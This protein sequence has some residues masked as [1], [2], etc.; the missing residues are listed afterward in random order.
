M[1]TISVQ[2]TRA[3]II[4]F[5]GLLMCGSVMGTK[6]REPRRLPEPTAKLEQPLNHLDDRDSLQWD[7]N[8]ATY[9]FSFPDQDDDSLFNVRFQAPDSC[10]LLGVWIML[11][12]EDGNFSAPN[13]AVVVWETGL[14]SFPGEMLTIDTIDWNDIAAFYPDWQYIDLSHHNHTFNAEQWFHIGITGIDYEPGDA[15]AFI[16][17]NGFPS[18]PCSSF[19]WA[20]SWWTIE[21]IYPNGYNLFFRAIVSTHTGPCFE[22]TELTLGRLNDTPCLYWSAVPDADSYTIWKS[23]NLTDDFENVGTTNETQ[24]ID[25]AGFNRIRGFYRVT[26]SCY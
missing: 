13:I 23:T 10:Q 5:V 7:N 11:Y 16:S 3:L 17:D 21:D 8:V 4:L 26:A 18:T 24:W 14:N 22:P 2:N 15:V 6:R 1:K 25:S 20:G 12:D 19:R 9:F